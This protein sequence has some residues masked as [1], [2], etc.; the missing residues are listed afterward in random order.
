MSRTLL[1]LL[2]L[3]LVATAAPAHDYTVGSLQIGHPWSRPVAAGMPVGVAYLSI[4]N[5]GKTE[6]VL[7]SA[8][9][10]AAARVEIHQTIVSEGMARMR[11]LPQIAIAPGATVKIAP[12]GIHLMLLGLERAFVL[13]DEVPLTLTFRD[14]GDVPVVIK[15][16]ARDV[17]ADA[18]EHEMSRTM[19]TVTVVARRPSSLPT[20]IPTTLE[21]VTGETV[22]RTINALD[23]ED[24]LKYFPSL[25]VRKRYVGD[26]DHA[27]LA[28]RASGTGNSAR[29]LVY[30]DGILLSNLLGNGATYTPRWGLVTPEEIARVDVLYGPFSAAYPGNSAGAVVDYV[31][32]MPDEFE[33]RASMTTFSEDFS[34]YSTNETYS[35]W[36]ASTSVGD[37]TGGTSWWVNLNRLDSD[38]HPLSYANKVVSTGTVGAAGTPV[39]G[40]VL[41]RNPRNQAWWLLGATSAVHTVQD[42][43]KIKLSQEIGDDWRA[44]Y[45]LGAWHNDATR[46]ATTWLRDASGA[47]VWNGL[48]NLDGRSFNVGAT[49]MGPS[50]A[51]LT[52]LIHGLSVRRRN[53]GGWDLEAAASLYDY[54]DDETRSPDLARPA[55]LLGGAGRI[56]DQGGTGWSTLALRARWHSPGAA[57]HLLELGLQDDRYRLRTRVSATTD[58]HDGGG[59]ARISAFRG[60]T[61]L[62][63]LYAQDT[64]TF[65]DDWQATLGLRVERWQASNGALSNASVTEPFPGRRETFL[66]PKAAL[67]FAVNPTLTL[68]ASVGRAAR[69]PTVAELYQGSI[70]AGDIVNNDPDLAAERSWTSELTA[71]C[72]FDHGEL[73]TT[74]FLEDTRDAL[75]SQVNVAG[76]G[77]VSTVQNVGLIRTRGVELVARTQAIELLELTASLTYARSRIEENDAFPA[78]VGK[79][80]PRVPEWRANAL[81][82]WRPT[83]RLSATLGARYS[84]RQYNQLDNSDPHGTAFTG[85]SRYVVADARVRYEFGEHWA[86]ALGVDNLGNERYW[87]FHPYTRRS[88][89]A[90]VSATL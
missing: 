21:G 27:V 7:L 36:Q 13:G 77:T 31:T 5:H 54:V 24:A 85:T 47:P 51:E 34:V 43:A 3:A 76:G 89:S 80:Q 28:S 42:H 45:T 56:A 18:A 57:R 6:E 70:V 63:S 84:G 40:A 15:I 35:G 88:Y 29:S 17:T 74:V 72:G 82:T 39:T 75:Y 69:L 9:S 50:R 11:P 49:E 20:Q 71:A 16:E 46:E 78:S 86:A 22:E 87:A 83:P 61:G 62:T 30:A 14:A 55:A 68:K 10:P 38:G 67:A 52:H 66:S 2:A 26:F 41:A 58:W 48:V 73:R 25:V 4:T 12:G 79:R 53:L 37:R 44:S 60:N 59:G 33:V 8:R 64:F 65:A 90:E 1:A 32:R 23:A 81:A 19:G